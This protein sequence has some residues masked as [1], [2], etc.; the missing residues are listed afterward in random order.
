MRNRLNAN[1]PMANKVSLKIKSYAS[2]K[3]S[4][5]CDNS[6]LFDNLV[7][8]SFYFFVLCGLKRSIHN[9]RDS[10]LIHSGI[11]ERFHE[12]TE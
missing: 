4:C 6:F 11:L 2:A 7:V 3:V 1:F 5:I 8:S 9:S 10:Y 12:C